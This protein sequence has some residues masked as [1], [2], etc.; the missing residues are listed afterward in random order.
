MANSQSGYGPAEKKVTILV[1]GNLIP[2]T[3]VT[4]SVTSQNRDV[5][6]RTLGLKRYQH[7][8]N[9]ENHTLLNP[10][11]STP[12][13]DF[14]QVLLVAP[15]DVQYKN[16]AFFHIREL[17][18]SHLQ[19]SGVL[20]LSLPKKPPFLNAITLLTPRGVVGLGIKMMR[21]GHRELLPASCNDLWGETPSLMALTIVTAA[22][23]SSKEGAGNA[24]IFVRDRENGG[25]CSQVLTK[26]DA[27]TF[28]KKPS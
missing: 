24:Y 26:Q 8:A 15:P 13:V 10:P 21:R 5:R 9:K 25:F 2:F 16:G 23:I 12:D 3:Q 1:N 19:T 17:T 22:D 6:T 11:L 4:R 20:S 7:S 14:L 27:F 28:E 18:P